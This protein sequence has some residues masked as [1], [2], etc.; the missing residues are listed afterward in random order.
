VVSRCTQLDSG[1]RMIDAILTNTLLPR[2]SQELLGRLGSERAVKRVEVDVA[3][4]D[5]QYRFE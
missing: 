3:G 1:G 4:G 2:I 5:F